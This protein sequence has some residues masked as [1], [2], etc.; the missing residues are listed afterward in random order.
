MAEKV[1]IGSCCSFG[2]SVYSEEKLTWPFFSI[3][4]SAEVKCQERRVR[5]AKQASF[6]EALLPARCLIS[7]ISHDPL[8]VPK[9]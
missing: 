7:P 2:S 6:I 3:I 8:A 9:G 4:T 5:E 1:S